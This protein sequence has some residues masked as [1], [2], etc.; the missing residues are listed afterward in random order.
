MTEQALTFGPDDAL[1]GVFAKP[2]T[3]KASAPVV[4]LTNAGV[5]P[6]QGAHR[7]N[8]KIARALAE[9][10]IASLRFDLSG[11]GDSLSIGNT[12]GVIAQARNDFKSAMDWVQSNAGAS[13]F[14]VFGVCSSAVHAYN[15]ALADS[16]VAGL[17]MFDG[18]WYRSRFTTIVRDLKRAADGDWASRFAAIKRRLT[19]AQ[20]EAAPQEE[21]AD[22]LAANNP[23]GSPPLA[24]YT[25]ALQTLVD[26]GT[27]I[28]IL[29]G[30]SVIDSY[31]YAGQFKDVFGDEPFYPHVRCEYHPDIDHTFISRHGQKKM[32]R[33]ACDWVSAHN[34]RAKA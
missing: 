34:S 31:S 6:R 20:I 9:K 1:V 27:D 14:L 30:G 4:L 12:D 13:S 2:A 25:A 21:S 17:L 3:A 28:Y 7:M 10:G 16:R 33:L 11:N 19:T 15:I 26:R 29:Y 18:F 22:L 8:V 24:D 23:F 5:L 32:V